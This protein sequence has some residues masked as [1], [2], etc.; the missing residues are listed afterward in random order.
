MFRDDVNPTTDEIRA[1]ASDPAA[2]LPMQDYDLVLTSIPEN[3]QL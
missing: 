3:D 1:W 2:V